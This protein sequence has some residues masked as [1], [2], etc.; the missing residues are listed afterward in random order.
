[1]TWIWDGTGAGDTASF[2]YPF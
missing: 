2:F 1:L